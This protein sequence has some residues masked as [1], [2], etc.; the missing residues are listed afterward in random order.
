MYVTADTLDEAVDIMRGT[1]GTDVDVVFMRDGLEMEYTL[2]RATINVNR[3]SSTMLEDGIGYICLF[4]FAG[5]CSEKFIAAADALV[6]QGAKGIIID[7]RDNPGGWMDDAEAI[8][9]YFLDTGV[10]CY[11][12][13]NDGSREYYRTKPGEVDVELVILVNENSASA[14]EVLTGALKDRKDATVVGVQSYGKGI[15][16][17]VLAIGEDEGMQLTVAQYFTPNGN[18]V[19]TIGI[20]PDVECPLPQG[21]KGIYEFAD[22]SDPQL[23][24]ALEIMQEKLK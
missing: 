3:V 20:T 17:S 6:K 2:T 13:Y 23:S 24:R 10:L 1:P 8:G 14:S 22:L 19:H 16:Q 21:D 15:V 11:L 5:D 12:E 7:L 18:A 4:E 9:D